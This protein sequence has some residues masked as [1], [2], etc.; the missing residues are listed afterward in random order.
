VELGEFNYLLVLVGVLALV[1]E[2]ALDPIPIMAVGACNSA[3]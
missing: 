3:N 1:L 2:G